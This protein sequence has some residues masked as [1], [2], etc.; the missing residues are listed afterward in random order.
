MDHDLR[1]SSRSP[2]DRG[3]TPAAT[4]FGSAQPG[5]Q[6]LRRWLRLRT[7]CGGCTGGGG[8]TSCC[9]RRRR[10]ASRSRGLGHHQDGALRRPTVG[11]RLR[12]DGR[13]QTGPVGVRGRV[14]PASGTDASVQ[15]GRPAGEHGCTES[16]GRR[17]VRDHP[18]VCGGRAV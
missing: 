5:G 4:A 16:D 11:G 3:S 2:R 10:G 7:G 6:K 1:G 14:V 9:C 13:V 12:A 15:P 18:Q 17:A 8:R